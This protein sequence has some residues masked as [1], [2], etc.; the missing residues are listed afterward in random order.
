[1]IKNLRFVMLS[2]IAMVCGSVSAQEVVFDFTE[3]VWGIGTEQVKEAGSYTYNGYTI[4]LTPAGSG[5]YFRWYTQNYVLLGKQGATLEFPPFDFEVEKI[6]I[7]GRE[8][9]SGSTKQNI[10]VGETAVSTETTGAIGEN[11]YKIN[12]DYQTAGTVYTL[13]INSNHNTQFTTIKF[14]K[15]GEA[16]EDEGGDDDDDNNDNPTTASSP[17]TVAEAL[18]ACADLGI[19]QKLYNGKDVYV[20]GVITKIDEVSINY[21]NATYYISDDAAGSN[22]LEVFRGYSLNGAKFTS[23]KEIELGDTVIVCGVITNYNGIIEFTTG[24][25]LVSLKKGEGNTGGGNGG[26]DNPTTPSVPAEGEGTATSPYNVTAALAT[27]SGTGVYVKAYI[28]GSVNGASLSS[29][30][31]FSATTE[32]LTNLLIAASADETNVSNCMPVQL[33][34]GD[35][36]TALNLAD[37]VGN[38]KKEVVL[39]GNIENYFGVTGLKTITFAILE[40]QEIGTNPGGNTGISNITTTAQYGQTYN[41]AGQKVSDNYRGLIIKDGKKILVK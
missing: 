3:D 21:G 18:Q 37:N 10:Y 39:Y 24:S 33:P 19:N 15:K 28:V 27:G 41:M 20:A 13:K 16:G 26:D 29:G 34:Q 25:K 31:I 35:I 38:Y 32:V 30:A 7:T 17:W 6:V 4:K 1:M 23:E 9:A 11:T 8:G 5:N 22:S 36:R 40:G 14:Y 12:A 2:L